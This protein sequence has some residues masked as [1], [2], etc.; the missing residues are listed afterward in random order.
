MRAQRNSGGFTLVELLVVVL[1][2]AVLLAV[3]VP[4]FLQ[5][6]GRTQDTAAKSAAELARRVMFMAQPGEGVAVWQESEPSLRFVAGHRPSTGPGEVSAG[7]LGSSFI[8]AVLSDSGR[9]FVLVAPADAPPTYGAVQSHC[10]ANAAHLHA[11]APS[12]PGTTVTFA[13]SP[14]DLILASPGLVG[15]W[16]LDDVSEITALDLGPGA[17]DGSFVNSPD[18]G[19]PGALPRTGTAARFNDSWVALPTIDVDW[20]SGVTIAAWVRPLSTSFYA[21]VVDLGNGAAADNLWLGRLEARQEFGFEVRPTGTG[22]DV[23]GAPPGSLENG[24]WQHVAAALAPDGTVRLYR[25]GFLVASRTG[26]PRMPAAVARSVN[27]IG[28][29]PWSQ[30]TWQGDIDEVAVWSRALTGAELTAIVEAG[31]P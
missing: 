24:T 6:R 22:L 10:R 25:D 14:G 28:R 16:P 12:W 20:S 30:P 8:A 9:C 17:L 21:R 29:S 31:T 7:M 23:V 5:S 1:V 19:V 27:T 11:T 13:P 4:T 2:V 18:L 26:Y 15:Y 3:A